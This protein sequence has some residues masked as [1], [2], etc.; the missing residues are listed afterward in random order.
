VY[1]TDCGCEEENGY[2]VSEDR[3]WLEENGECV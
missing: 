1:R 2:R 3:M